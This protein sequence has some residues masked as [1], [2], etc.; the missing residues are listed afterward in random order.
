MPRISD[1]NDGEA[2]KVGHFAVIV[3]ET[4]LATALVPGTQMLLVEDPT[5]AS[6]QFPLTLKSVSM[7]AIV[8]NMA[9]TDYTYRLTT[10]KPRDLD[11]LRRM[12]K[13]GVVK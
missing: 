12:K 13:S 3:D 11:A 1:L 7:K 4:G 6:K 8:F 10:G 5:S 9:G 2:P